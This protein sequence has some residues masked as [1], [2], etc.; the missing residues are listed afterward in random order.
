MNSSP[1]LRSLTA[2]WGARLGTAAALAG[3]L[4]GLPARPALAADPQVSLA[5]SQ[6]WQL[7]NTQGTWTPYVITVRDEGSTGFTGDVF[8]VPNDTRAVTPDTYPR[9]RSPISVG[10]GSKRYE[11]LSVVDGPG[12]CSAEV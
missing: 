6:R 2:R 12:G 3:L 9:Y 11:G 7:A 5:V 8:L 1:A 10:R 4:L